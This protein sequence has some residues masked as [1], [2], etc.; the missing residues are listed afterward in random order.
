MDE[1]LVFLCFSP[2]R[3]ARTH[4]VTQKFDAMT[5]HEQTAVAAQMQMIDDGT[6]GKKLVWRV[7]EMALVPVPEESHGI[8]YDGD[9]YVVQY[10]YSPPGTNAERHI[11]YFWLVT[12]SNKLI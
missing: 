12:C 7:E 2:G 3:I 8:F 6:T 4:S 10:S 9:A 5:M 1:Y 11:L